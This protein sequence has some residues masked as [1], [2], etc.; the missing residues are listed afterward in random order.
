MSTQEKLAIMESTTLFENLNPEEIDFLARISQL[1]DFEDED[2][3]VKEGDRDRSLFIV[4]KGKVD[5]VKKDEDGVERHITTLKEGEF[6][7]EMALIDKDERSASIKAN[8][9]VRVLKLSADNLHMFAR[10]YQTGFSMM[11]INIAKVLSRRLRAT[12]NLLVKSLKSGIIEQSS[13]E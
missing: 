1:L 4:A 8:G 7:G 12:N 2:Y 11:V 5:V 3:L 13:G 9:D 6:F 10:Q